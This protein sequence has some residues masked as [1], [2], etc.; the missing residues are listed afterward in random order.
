MEFLILRN[1]SLLEEHCA[2]CSVAYSSEPQK[3]KWRVYRKRHLFCEKKN[4]NLIG[5]DKWEADFTRPSALTEFW[6]YLEL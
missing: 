3:N 4:I 5:Q 1:D 2:I 6:Q